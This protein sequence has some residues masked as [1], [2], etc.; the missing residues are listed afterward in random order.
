MAAPSRTCRIPQSVQN[1]HGKLENGRGA[2][3]FQ[4]SFVATI[5]F[6][7][8]SRQIINIL[9]DII[10]FKS[11]TVFLHHVILFA[12]AVYEVGQE[13]LLVRVLVV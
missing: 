12:L 7:G 13:L 1:E 6:E 2:G 9:P 4:R 11:I 3:C 8:Y 10:N 5:V